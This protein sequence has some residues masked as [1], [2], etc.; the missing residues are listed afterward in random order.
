[1][2]SISID[3]IHYNR[4]KEKID[5]QSDESREKIKKAVFYIINN[6]IQG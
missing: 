2:Q 5:I 6:K 3:V 4:Q 1:M